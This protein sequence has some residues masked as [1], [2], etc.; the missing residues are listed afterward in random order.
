MSRK[1]W[2][3]T[4]GSGF[5]GRSLIRHILDNIEV[6][7]INIDIKEIDIRHDRLRSILID[8]RDANQLQDLHGEKIDRI[9]HLAALAKEPGFDWEDYFLTNTGGTQNIINLADAVDCNEI[10]FTSTM[11]V[12]KA[13]EEQKKTDSIKDPD[14]AYGISKALAEEELIQW[15][16]SSINHKLII[17]RPGI[18][19]GAGENGNFTRM[20]RSMRS[21]T[22]VFV[23][24]KTTVKGC[25]YVKDLIELL[26][27]REMKSPSR[28]VHAVYS[29][30]YTI[31][32]IHD[33]IAKVFKISPRAKTLPYPLLLFVA[34]IVNIILPNSAI[35]PR[36]IQKLF[37]STNIES[38]TNLILQSMT[39]GNIVDALED[40]KKEE[41]L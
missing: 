16:I 25:I 29:D 31:G 13:S 2:M 38:N 36:R 28:I 41:V 3:I 12:F 8:I 30:N 22:F 11:M 40:W 37:F 19:F 14:T 21:N 39:Y 5:I 23:G 4:G 20:I 7:I 35:H 33:A 26:V 10:V 27:Q 17:F 9:F 18:V 15:E 1:T 34:R 24:R 6:D 32:Q